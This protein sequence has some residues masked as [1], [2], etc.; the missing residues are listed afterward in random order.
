MNCEW[1]EWPI[2]RV[3]IWCF[4]IVSS[5]SKKKRPVKN[6]QEPD[7]S[8]KASGSNVGKEE[9]PG[10]EGRGAGGANKRT[11]DSRSEGIVLQSSGRISKRPRKEY[12]PYSPPGRQGKNASTQ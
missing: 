7:K 10:A 12:D 1:P 3:I 9:D 2:W 5:Q 11:L 8:S 6:V 4:S